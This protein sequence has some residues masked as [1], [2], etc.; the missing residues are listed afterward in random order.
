MTSA[1]SF[2]SKFND[3]DKVVTVAEC[4]NIVELKSEELKIAQDFIF[5]QMESFGEISLQSRE[6]DRVT[7]FE[8]TKANISKKT[9]LPYMGSKM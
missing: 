7:R 1:L 8:K 3:N 6:V 5:K 4:Q 2:I 9:T